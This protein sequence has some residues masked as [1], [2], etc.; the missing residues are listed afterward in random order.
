M[1]SFGCTIPVIG[2]DGIKSCSAIVRTMVWKTSDLPL[3]TDI[4]TCNTFRFGGWRKAERYRRALWG[5]D[6]RRINQ[7]KERIHYQLPSATLLME[8]ERGSTTVELLFLLCTTILCSPMS[9]WSSD[10]AIWDYLLLVSVWLHSA[11]AFNHPVVWRLHDTIAI[12]LWF[13]CIVLF[14]PCT[15]LFIYCYFFFTFFFKVG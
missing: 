2:W 14:Y 5:Q 4:P 3:K 11:S 7:F 8:Q 10:Y 9:D 6:L 15:L 12:V 1:L 13:D